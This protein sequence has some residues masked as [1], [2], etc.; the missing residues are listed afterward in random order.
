MEIWIVNRYASWCCDIRT[1]YY[2]F[3][4]LANVKK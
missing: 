1:S 2:S 3:A 4:I